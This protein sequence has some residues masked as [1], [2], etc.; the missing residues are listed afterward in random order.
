MRSDDAERTA[1]LVMGAV[2]RAVRY[3]PVIGDLTI[4]TEDG[5]ELRAG[6]DIALAWLWAEH[7]NGAEKWAAMPK[8][9]Q[10]A[11]VSDALGELRR[12]ARLVEATP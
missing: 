4:M 2:E 12:A 6:S 3:A 1:A 5:T 10:W 11:D 7:E 8:A 9:L